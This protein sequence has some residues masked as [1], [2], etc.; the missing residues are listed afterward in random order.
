MTSSA[1]PIYDPSTGNPDGS[2]R[3]AFTGN[4]IPSGRISSIA[5]KVVALIPEPNLTGR[6]EQLFCSTRRATTNS[7]R[8]TRRVDWA[9]TEKL[10]MFVRYSDYLYNVTQA[11]VF[12]PILS[13]ANNALQFGNIYACRLPQ[14]TL[15][16][17][18]FVIDGLFGITHS[19]QSQ[20][21]PNTFQ[22]LRT[23]CTRYSRNKSRKFAA[24]RRNAPVQFHYLFILWQSVRSIDL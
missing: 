23:G 7:T 2:G 3:T 22:A 11:T 15:L 24:R 19:T 5:Q 21:P 18:H 4:I 1:N 10:R 9:A 16:T 8:L 12:G 17:P 20:Q 6:I 13:G 14:R